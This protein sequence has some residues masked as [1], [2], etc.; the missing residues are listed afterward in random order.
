[1]ERICCGCVFKSESKSARWWTHNPVLRCAVVLTL[2][3]FPTCLG[4]IDEGSAMDQPVSFY[5]AEVNLTYMDPISNK[6]V[7]ES[8]DGKYGAKSLV[9]P[10]TGLALHVRNKDNKTHGCDDYQIHIPKEK[11]IALVERGH[12]YFTDKIKI[13]TKKYNASAVVIYNNADE[14]ITIMQHTGKYAHIGTQ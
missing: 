8:Y 14:G 6:P 4:N 2:M 1:M 9:E 12:C 10:R 13:A 7:H 5:W 11:W 3:T